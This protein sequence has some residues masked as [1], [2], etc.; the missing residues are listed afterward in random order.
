MMPL[1]V[2]AL[3]DT[4]F[5][6]LCIEKMVCSKCESGMDAC[7]SYFHAS[8]RDKLARANFVKSKQHPNQYNFGAIAEQG[9]IL[10]LSCRDS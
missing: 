2:I 10:M 5:T 7:K 8:E 6:S 9:G 4:R 3:P 1:K